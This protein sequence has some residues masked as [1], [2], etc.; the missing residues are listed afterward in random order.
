MQKFRE[1]FFANTKTDYERADQRVV[2]DS[3]FAFTYFIEKWLRRQ[4]SVSEKNIFYHQ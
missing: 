1:F 4:A 2:I 3:D